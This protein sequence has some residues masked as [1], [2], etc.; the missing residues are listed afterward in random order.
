VFESSEAI[1][2]KDADAEV[3]VWFFL[4]PPDPAASKFNLEIGVTVGTPPEQGPTLSFE[5][6]PMTAAEGH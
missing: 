2:G 1:F 4:T 3:D 5:G 6:L